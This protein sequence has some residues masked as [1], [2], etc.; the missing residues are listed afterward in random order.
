VLVRH[1]RT[2]VLMLDWVEGWTFDEVEA[3]LFG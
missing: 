1:M 2:G 3:E